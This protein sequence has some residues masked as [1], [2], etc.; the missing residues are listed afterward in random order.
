MANLGDENI[1]LTAN[2]GMNFWFDQWIYMASVY[3]LL[4]ITVAVL[5][6]MTG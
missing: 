6:V 2:G 5:F 3:L 4:V 1:D